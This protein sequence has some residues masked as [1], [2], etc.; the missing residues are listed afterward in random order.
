MV[1]APIFGSTPH[2]KV[3]KNICCKLHW[4]AIQ[5][6]WQS[7]TATHITCEWALTVYL[8]KPWIDTFTS[9]W[10]AKENPIFSPP[11]N[12][13]I[14]ERPST[15]PSN[16]HFFTKFILN[17]VVIGLN[18]TGMNMGLD[19][20]GRENK[21]SSVTEP[22]FN[23]CFPLCFLILWIHMTI[24]YYWEIRMWPS[25]GT[26]SVFYSETFKD[27]IRIPALHYFLWIFTFNQ[28]YN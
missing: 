12:S 24:E 26:Y 27:I 21:K 11:Y 9:N 13:S 18:L 22:A 16:H 2:H 7:I 4:G 23:L 10:N 6:E 1:H 3:T 8:Y 20:R 17:P 28:L 15:I 19:F 25:G 5:N 14:K